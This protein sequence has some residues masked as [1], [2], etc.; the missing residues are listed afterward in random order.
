MRNNKFE[1][2]KRM[3]RIITVA[4]IVAVETLIFY[5]TW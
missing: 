3:L 4:L 5:I 1:Q 2:Y